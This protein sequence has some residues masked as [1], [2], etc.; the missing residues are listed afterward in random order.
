MAKRLDDLDYYAL[1]GVE[2]DATV[3]AI[4]IAFHRFARKYHPDRFAG[5]AKL[6]ARNMRIYRRGTEGYRVLTNPEGRRS[7][8]AVLAAGQ[9]RYE[10]DANGPRQPSMPPGQSHTRAAARPFITKANAAIGQEDFQQA[11]L[12]LQVAIQRDP[13]NPELEAMLKD[14]I[15]KLEE[16]RRG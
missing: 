7:Y 5:D 12:H 1:L 16:H 9:L 11:K 4:K 15:V 2:R 6:T 13:D 8:D 3:D 14:V 10:G